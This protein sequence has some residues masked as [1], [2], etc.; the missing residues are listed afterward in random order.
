MVTLLISCTHQAQTAR[1]EPLP[2]IVDPYDVPISLGSLDLACFGTVGGKDAGLETRHRRTQPRLRS[3][4]YATDLSFVIQF[5]QSDKSFRDR[6][7]SA[8][9]CS[10]FP[11]IISLS[12]LKYQRFLVQTLWS[13]S[14]MWQCHTYSPLRSKVAR[15][16]V[17]S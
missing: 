2:A 10:E 3:A 9:Q 11:A 15:M 4:Y 17:I 14:R 6:T 5:T 13:C 12:P 8:P 16:R 1:R 7:N